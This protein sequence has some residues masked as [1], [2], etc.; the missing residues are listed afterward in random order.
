VERDET[1]QIIHAMSR[2]NQQLVAD[3]PVEFEKY[4]LKF[5]TSG[6]LPI[7]LEESIEY[8]SNE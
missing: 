6:E 2:K 3:E 1:H 4:R 8:T 5:K 7:N